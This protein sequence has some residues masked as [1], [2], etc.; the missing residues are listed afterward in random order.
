MWAQQLENSHWAP[1]PAPTQARPSRSG[2]WALFSTPGDARGVGAGPGQNG[3]GPC[4]PLGRTGPNPY[5]IYLKKETGS[6]V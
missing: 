3:L 2:Q 5:L 6:H 4:G 1:G